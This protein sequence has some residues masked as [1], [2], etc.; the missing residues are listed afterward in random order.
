MMVTKMM[1]MAGLAKGRMVRMGMSLQLRKV[2]GHVGP[3]SKVLLALTLVVMIM[4]HLPK[5]GTER[6]WAAGRNRATRDV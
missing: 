1:K 4:G 6:L 2:L 5:S 3:E